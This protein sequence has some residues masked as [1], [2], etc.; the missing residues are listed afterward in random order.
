MKTIKANDYIKTSYL[1]Y[2]NGSQR[3]EKYARVKGRVGTL[4]LVNFSDGTSRPVNVE[5][6]VLVLT[7]PNYV[8]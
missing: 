5:D 6:S 4:L 1:D 2:G 3:V 7:G 8:S